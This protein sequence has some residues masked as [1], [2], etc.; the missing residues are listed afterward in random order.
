M[1]K[2]GPICAE[3]PQ[4]LRISERLTREIATGRLADGSRLP[5][6]RQMAAEMGVA[7]GTLRRALQSLT[8]NGLLERV[9]GSGNY[10]R[11]RQGPV[12]IYGLFRLERPGGGDFPTAEILSAVRL[13]KPVDLP[14]F[15]SSAHAYRIRRLR[16]L[17]GRA[18]AVEEIWL[19]GSRASRMIAGEISE[20]LYLHYANVLGF[21]IT[22]VEDR[23]SVAAMPDWAPQILAPCC[24]TAAGFFE[25]LGWAEDGQSAEYSRNWF[26]PAS[27]QYVA[28]LS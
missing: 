12:G 1:T 25:R 5:P 13:R 16:R 11:A 6:E 27:A 2:V 8:E 22:R 18:V 20:S 23:C 3:L 15:G 21:R 14:P 9:Q 4:H 19:D 24:G 17:D 7:V 26:D 28:R 10:V